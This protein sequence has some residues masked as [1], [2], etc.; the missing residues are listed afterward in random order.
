MNPPDPNS[1][2]S[3]DP[4]PVAHFQKSTLEFVGQEKRGDNL[5]NFHISKVSKENQKNPEMFLS[6]SEIELIRE[7][8][9]I[10]DELDEIEKNFEK[11]LPRFL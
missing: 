4:L 5:E 6:V 1:D 3:P 8:P 10:M 2:F 11:F 9:G 7:F